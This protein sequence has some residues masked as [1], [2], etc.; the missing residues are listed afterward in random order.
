MCFIVFQLKQFRLSKLE[1]LSDLVKDHVKMLLNVEPSLRPD[2]DQISKVRGSF[3][4]DIFICLSLILFVNFIWKFP[5][6]GWNL[7]AN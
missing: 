4:K 3:Y 1:G 7:K 6:N 2:A 5:S